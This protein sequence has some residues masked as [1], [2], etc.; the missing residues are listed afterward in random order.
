MQSL[1]LVHAIALGGTHWPLTHA[2]LR[3]SELTIQATLPS[4]GTQKLS[5]HSSSEAQSLSMTQS[6]G[7]GCPTHFPLLH[8]PDRQSEFLVQSTFVIGTQRLFVHVPLSHSLS[9][10]HNK[11][12]THLLSLQTPER[13]CEFDVHCSV[14]NGNPTQ[15][16]FS[17][18]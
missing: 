4:I 13:H 10:V 1:L 5:M 7:N 8:S 14:I 12:G 11:F 9:F 16:P 15:R 6:E 17:Q 2:P 18:L 3:Q